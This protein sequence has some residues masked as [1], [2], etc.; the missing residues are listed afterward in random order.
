MGK[1]EAMGCRIKKA[2]V[3]EEV[4]N[5]TKERVSVEVDGVEMW[6]WIVPAKWGAELGISEWSDDQ[7][8][9]KMAISLTMVKSGLWNR[10][11]AD[12]QRIVQKESLGG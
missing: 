5:A 7:A 12:R 6:G 9:G 8:K 1:T 3:S 10:E 11:E 2:V 4:E